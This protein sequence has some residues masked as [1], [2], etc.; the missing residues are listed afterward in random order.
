M[1][2]SEA[3]F[4]FYDRLKGVSKGYAS[5]DYELIDF[6]NSPLVKLEIML[7]REPVDALSMI[8]HKDKAY[9]WG[10]KSMRETKNSDTKAAI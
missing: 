5:L 3:V 2:L 4:E 7:N 10:K 6:R 8:I 1:P 9:A